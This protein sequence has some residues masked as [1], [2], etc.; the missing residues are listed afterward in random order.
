MSAVYDM[1]APWLRPSVLAQ[2]YGYRGRGEV[3]ESTKW[4]WARSPHGWKASLSRHPRSR[5]AQIRWR[6]RN[7]HLYRSPVSRAAINR[8]T[9]VIDDRNRRLRIQRGVDD[10]LRALGL[11]P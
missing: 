7:S 3:D 8:F 9:R 6:Y 5:E 4:R 2:P 10:E 11:T 1:T